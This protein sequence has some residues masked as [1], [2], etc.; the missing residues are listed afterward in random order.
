MFI[1]TSKTFVY[2]T[3]IFCQ[4]TS[5]RVTVYSWAEWHTPV[6]PS[7]WELR[8]ENQQFKTNWAMQYVLVSTNQPNQRTVVAVFI[9]YR[10]C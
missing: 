7:T 6:I 8:Q 1:K 2:E 9:C 3:L 5:L 10:H 4:S